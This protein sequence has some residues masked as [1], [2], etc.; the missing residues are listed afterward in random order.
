MNKIWRRG[1]AAL[2]GL[3][4]WLV[5]ASVALA[6]S[7]QS[8]PSH[9]DVVPGGKIDGLAPVL[10]Y[11]SSGPEQSISAGTLA[12]ATGLTVPPGTAIAEICV[13]TA[14]VRYR[15]DGA[16][17]FGSIS[18]TTL[19]VKTVTLGTIAVGQVIGDRIGNV[20]AGTKITG[21]SGLSWTVN[22]SQT[23]AN[24]IIFAG[25]APTASVGIPAVASSSAPFCFQYGGPLSVVQFIAISGSPTMDISYYYQN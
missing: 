8:P 20:S 22:N 18:G 4:A 21:G 1:A 25:T 24:E 14:G 19:T 9:F 12:S 13:E 15:D 23:T 7:P 2:L 6:Q 5:L 11:N 10:L 17:F 3:A 16:Q